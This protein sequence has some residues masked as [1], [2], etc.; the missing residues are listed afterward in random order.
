MQLD[1]IEQLYKLFYRE[2]SFR[3]ALY[4]LDPVL[5]RRFTN[6]EIRV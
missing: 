5:F 4:K 3:T 1:P 6:G 2:S